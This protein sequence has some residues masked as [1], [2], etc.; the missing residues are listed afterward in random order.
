MAAGPWLFTCVAADF[1]HFDFYADYSAAQQTGSI[2]LTTPFLELRSSN[3]PEKFNLGFL[4]SSASL[5]KKL[6]V[7]IKAGNLSASGSLSRLNSP[8]LSNG[9]SPFSNGIISVSGISASLPSYSTF[10]K[11]AG[12]FFQIKMNQLVKHP[13]L[14]SVNLLTSPEF[15]SPIFS[16]LISDKYLS[17]R[18]TLS[19]SWTCG[20]FLYEDNYSSSF[21]LESPAYG[22]GTHFCCLAQFSAEYKTKKRKQTFYAGF[23]SAI[24]ESP[25]GPYTAAW[26]IDL[27]A[28][29]KYTEVFAS[30]F[31]NQYEELLTSSEKKLSPSTQFKAGFVSKM[32]LLTK[33]QNLI[34]LKFGIN[35]FSKINL[36]QTEHPL[37]LNI[38]AQLTS[39]ITSLSLTLSGTATLLSPAAD[40]TPQSL[41]AAAFSAQLKNTWYFKYIT[42]SLTL[43]AE[44]K[45]STRSDSPDTMKYKFLLN[46]TNN[47]KHKLSGSCAF[48]FTSADRIISDK[49]LS[50]T[51]NCK[52]TF[53][54]LTVTGKISL[55]TGF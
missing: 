44:K 10:S 31:L 38:G 14:L 4:F 26:R 43:S 37:R 41:E 49:K 27:K 54:K 51:L 25:F 3:R 15:S 7:E 39:D 20:Q 16:T 52:M 34:F 45:F 28:S 24:Y 22:E 30:A 17:N 1:F 9:T 50:A 6:P 5:Y 8:E 13:C 33:H 29:I 47:N 2:R 21:F 35:A 23:M 18:L 53:K 19:T 48:S 46:L 40:Q 55:E 42:H 12:V 11:P 32:P 36:T